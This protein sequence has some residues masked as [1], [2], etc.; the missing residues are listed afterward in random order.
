MDGCYRAI[1]Y[2]AKCRVQESR[3]L[4]LLTA[5]T[6]KPG[7]PYVRGAVNTNPAITRAITPR[8]A[9]TILSGTLAFSGGRL[10]VFEPASD[11]GK[12]TVSLNMKLEAAPATR[13]DIICAGR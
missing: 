8:A 11:T 9:I 10:R 6:L 5:S 1:R 7:E 12:L 4:R 2:L 13:A 3:I